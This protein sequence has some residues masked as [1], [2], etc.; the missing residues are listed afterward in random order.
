MSLDNHDRVIDICL[1]ELVGDVIVLEPSVEILHLVSELLHIIDDDECITLHEGE[2]EDEIVE[3]FTL[4]GVDI[5]EIKKLQS[6][7]WEYS[8]GIS[9]DRVDIVEFAVFKMFNRLNMS[10]PGV[11]DSGDSWNIPLLVG[12]VRG[13]TPLGLP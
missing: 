1:L 7:S 8:L 13:G 3:V 4:H 9:P 10:I 5:Y 12:G 11:F 6:Q 2:C